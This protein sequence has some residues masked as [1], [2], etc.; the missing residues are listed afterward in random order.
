MATSGYTTMGLLG[1][2]VSA[3]LLFIAWRL[4]ARSVTLP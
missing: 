4:P 3:P 2:L 1:A